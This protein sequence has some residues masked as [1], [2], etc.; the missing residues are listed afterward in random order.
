LACRVSFGSTQI[1]KSNPK[2]PA[3]STNCSKN[4]E[5]LI[6]VKLANG[7]HLSE[8]EVEDV[9]FSDLGLAES[10]VEEFLRKNIEFVFEE[11]ET[12]LIV[13][14]QVINTAGGRSDLVALDENG[15]VVLIEIKRDAADIKA[16]REPFEFQAIRYAASLAMIA[17]VDDLVGK[18][19]AR[20]IEKHRAEFPESQLTCPELGR[21]IATDFLEQNSAQRTFNQKQRIILLASDFDE[22]TLSAVAWLISNGVDI[23][24]FRITPRRCRDQHFVDAS[25]V[26]PPDEI[27][28]FYIDIASSARGSAPRT[29]A[30]R[31]R[32]SL[33]RMN[34]LIQWG[35]IKPGDVLEI[36]NHADSEAAVVDHKNVRRE[37]KTMTFNEWGTGITG[38]SSICIYDWAKKK[39]DARTL[40]QLRKEKMDEIEGD[41]QDEAMISES[42]DSSVP[43]PEDI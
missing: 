19:F 33:P 43:V 42:A 16:R 3:S 17:D 8:D 18:I 26:L 30:R 9:T 36:V 15:S 12:L 13:G 32:A 28:S 2:S 40:S 38:W 31:T 35:L 5:M 37:E 10:H 14:Q 4:E 24:A 20:Y 29:E 21:R 25:R 11:S 6:P 34:K 39:D 1:N 41:K 27:E 23:A 22:Q 7:L